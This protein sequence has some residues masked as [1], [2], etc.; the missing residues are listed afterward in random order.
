MPPKKPSPST[1]T[2]SKTTSQKPAGRA[3]AKPT[4]KKPG[5]TAAKPGVG[6]GRVAPAKKGGTS[7]TKGQA[8]GKENT[9]TS[10]VRVASVS[11][12]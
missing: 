3:A 1:K 10:Q 6:G 7:P 12:E 9:A 2:G 5:T 4:V 8:K 11:I